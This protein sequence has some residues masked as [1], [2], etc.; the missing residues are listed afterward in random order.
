M[1]KT[2]L[3]RRRFIAGSASLAASSLVSPLLRAHAAPQPTE[4][5]SNWERCPDRIW[6][7]PEYWANPLQDWRVANGRIECTNAAPDRNVHV[8]TR[9][10]ADRSGTLDMRVRAG[11]LGSGRVATVGSVG[12]RIGAQGPLLVPQQPDLRPRARGRHAET[13][14]YSLATSVAPRRSRFRM[15]RSCDLLPSRRGTTTASRSARARAVG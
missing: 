14:R 1:P 8:L 5:R 4:W 15:T 9:Q 7:G 2:K 13:A 12:F 3:T 10:L 6:L 11:S